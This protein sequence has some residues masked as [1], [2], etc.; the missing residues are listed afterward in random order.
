MKNETLYLNPIEME[1]NFSLIEME[2]GFREQ[3]SYLLSFSKKLN[4]NINRLR[5]HQLWRAT[6]KKTN[7]KDVELL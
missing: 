6:P 3:H 1:I 7:R 5:S 4:K 2:S